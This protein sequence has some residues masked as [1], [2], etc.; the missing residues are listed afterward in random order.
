MTK[1]NLENRKPR[2][3]KVKEEE[4]IR[5]LKSTEL[6]EEDEEPEGHVRNSHLSSTSIPLVIIWFSFFTNLLNCSLLYFSSVTA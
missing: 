1:G 3:V 5:V 2:S 6:I 4:S